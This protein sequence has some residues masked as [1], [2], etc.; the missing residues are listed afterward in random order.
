MRARVSSLLIYSNRKSIKKQ[1][2]LEGRDVEIGMDS[3]YSFLTDTN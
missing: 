3:D 1:K 2:E